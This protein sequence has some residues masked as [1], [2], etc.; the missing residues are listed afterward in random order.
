[1]DVFI[2][3]YEKSPS[4]R[5]QKARSFVWLTGKVRFPAN[6][7]GKRSMIGT[8][9][10]DEI[11]KKMPTGKTWRGRESVR[12]RFGER[13]SGVRS[14]MWIFRN[15]AHTGVRSFRFW[16]TTAWP[17]CPSESKPLPMDADDRPAPLRDDREHSTPPEFTLRYCLLVHV[18]GREQNSR[19]LQFSLS[20][21]IS[22]IHVSVTGMTGRSSCN[23]PGVLFLFFFFN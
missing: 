11:E 12:V 9:T 21:I 15:L 18:S 16:V 3:H 5:L 14:E 20:Q 8:L 23:L 2:F 19:I 7:R 6:D 17:C 22:I 1:M 13:T 10:D 4:N